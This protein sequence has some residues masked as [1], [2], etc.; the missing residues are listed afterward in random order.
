MTILSK[1][2]SREK[3]RES[4][5]KTTIPFFYER[6][7][8]HNTFKLLKGSRIFWGQQNSANQ[9]KTKQ[10]SLFREYNL[11]IRVRE[12]NI[13]EQPSSTHFLK[14]FKNPALFFPAPSRN[15]GEKGG[16]FKSR[17]KSC[18]WKFFKYFFHSKLSKYDKCWVQ[19]LNLWNFSG[20]QIFDPWL[21]R[22][23]STRANARNGTAQYQLSAGRKCWHRK[24]LSQ[25]VKFQ[26]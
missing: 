8:L 13:L 15:T 9:R 5:L 24:W 23:N 18:S 4:I 20:S 12:K 21:K 22:W 26:K 19:K 1:K 7:N 11:A 2:N 3:D 17:K 6:L 25:L 14:E 16:N 10:L